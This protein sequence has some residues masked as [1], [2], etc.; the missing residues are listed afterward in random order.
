[1]LKFNQ[2]QFASKVGI[3]QSELSRIE[4]DKVKGTSEL[5]LRRIAEALGEKISYLFEEEP[6]S[7]LYAIQNL[8]LIVVQ[9]HIEPRHIKI[10]E[11]VIRNL[12]KEFKKEQFKKN[13]LRIDFNK[14]R[15]L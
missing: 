5:L 14:R 2:R 9:L 8:P 12:L 6:K 13:S 15:K 3:R 7:N 11:E 10:I 4:N 1:M